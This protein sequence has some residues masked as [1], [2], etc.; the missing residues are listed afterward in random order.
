MEHQEIL[1]LLNEANDSKLVTRKWKIVN[2]NSNANYNAANEI[3]Y[4]T[5]V[6]KSSLCDYND[7]YILVTGDIAIKGHQETQVAFKS[8][9]PITKCI[10][11]TY[12]TTIDDGEDLELV[13]PMCNLIDYASIYSE[14]TGSLWFYSKD[15]ATNFNADIANTNNV[16]SFKYKINLLKYAEADEVNGILRNATI[17]VPL[18]YLSNFW[19]SLEMPLINCKVELKLK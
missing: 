11:K 9:A 17:A 2:D 15:E 1:N 13:I 10:T 19:R 6:L 4:N 14:A 8:Y 18:K 3:N 16:I 7:A 12:E 5:E